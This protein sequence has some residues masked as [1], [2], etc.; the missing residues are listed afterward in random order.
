MFSQQKRNGNYVMEALA[1]ATVAIILPY[2]D[3]S[4]QHIVHFKLTQHY[5]NYTSVK[6]GK[7]RIFIFRSLESSQ[8]YRTHTLITV[9][10]TYKATRKWVLI[11]G[12]C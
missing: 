7:N 3:V 10:H 4:N 1:N 6:L 9:G 12:K 8:S 5:V 2:I 11:G